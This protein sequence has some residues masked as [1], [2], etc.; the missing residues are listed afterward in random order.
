MRVVLAEGLAVS[1][2]VW[3]SDEAII[4]KVSRWSMDRDRRNVHVVRRRGVMMIGF[5]FDVDSVF[6]AGAASLG[7]G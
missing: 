5:H 6:P 2:G 3:Y 1:S 7:I 4:G